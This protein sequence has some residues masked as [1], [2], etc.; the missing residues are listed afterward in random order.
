NPVESFKALDWLYSYE[1]TELMVFGP[2]KAI[3]Q[4]HKDKNEEVVIHWTNP[5]GTRQFSDY[6]LK[7]PE[8]EYN[9]IRYIYTIQG[10]SSEYASEM[11]YMQY[12]EPCNAQCWEAWTKYADSS[13]HVPNTIS[14]TAEED[15]IRKPIVTN[16]QTLAWENAYNIIFHDDTVDSWDAVVEQ[17]KALGIDD[18]IKVTQDAYDRWLQ[19]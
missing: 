14:L 1:G 5:D 10:L 4:L 17:I 18:A 3:D 13:R 12:G 11:E 2:E 7:N 6:M 8:L 16:V 15:K 19:R 9:S